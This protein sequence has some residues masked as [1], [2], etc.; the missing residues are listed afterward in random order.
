MLK[1]AVVA[2]LICLALALS[3]GTVYW[4]LATATNVLAVYL[5]YRRDKAEKKG[6][7]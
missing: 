1:L 4:W 7:A 2:A 5:L 3:R 6:V